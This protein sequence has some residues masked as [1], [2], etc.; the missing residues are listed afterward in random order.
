MTKPTAP[1]DLEA[2]KAQ[3]AAIRARAD[4]RQQAAKQAVNSGVAL[5]VNPNADIPALCDLLD[6]ANARIAELERIRDRARSFR[7]RIY[8]QGNVKDMTPAEYASVTAILD[9]VLGISEEAPD[10]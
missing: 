7:E 4:A 5:Y 9:C 3:V 2:A 6:A 10:A 8:G 1:Y